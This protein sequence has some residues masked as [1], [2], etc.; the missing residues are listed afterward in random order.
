MLRGNGGI[1]SE[2]RRSSRG[3]DRHRGSFKNFWVLN[4]FGDRQTFGVKIQFFSYLRRVGRCFYWFL[5][6]FD[7]A[8]F[9]IKFAEESASFRAIR[10]F[11]LGGTRWRRPFGPDRK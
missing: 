2:P 3:V 7:F 11:A 10:R 6:L 8:V 4:P 5:C 9:I 1:N